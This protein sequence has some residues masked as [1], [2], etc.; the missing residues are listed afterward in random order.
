MIFILFFGN[1][2]GIRLFVFI[3]EYVYIDTVLLLNFVVMF[4]IDWK[5]NSCVV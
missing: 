3:S 4:D 2:D 1:I 5:F